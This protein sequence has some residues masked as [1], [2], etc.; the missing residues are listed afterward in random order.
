MPYRAPDFLCSPLH[1]WLNLHMD[2][3]SPNEARIDGFPVD[4]LDFHVF[5]GHFRMI[6]EP[7]TLRM[8][9]KSMEKVSAGR[10]SLLLCGRE[11]YEHEA[12]P[13]R[14]L[15]ALVVGRFDVDFR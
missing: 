8:E 6:F 14:A 1:D 2:L 12:A 3:T 9:G 11:G 7:R 5:F 4:F 13:R 10:L 15:L